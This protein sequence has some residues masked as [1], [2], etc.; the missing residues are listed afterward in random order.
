[1]LNHV[2]SPYIM[3]IGFLY[4]RY[5]SN[6]TDIWDKFRP[7]LYDKEPVRTSSK[8]TQNEIT[9]GKYVRNLLT[10]MEY[11]GTLL[12]RSHVAVEQDIKVTLM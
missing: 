10:D 9:V 3:C 1:M 8:T 12:P 6:P 7:F 5:S 2:D 4:L 11:C